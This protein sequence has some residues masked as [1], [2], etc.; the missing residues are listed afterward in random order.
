LIVEHPAARPEIRLV[1]QGRGKPVLQQLLK[2]LVGDDVRRAYDGTHGNGRG[3]R[4]RRHGHVDPGGYLHGRRRIADNR[5]VTSRRLLRS[6][7]GRESEG[8]GEGRA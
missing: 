7:V 5:L 4:R 8:E 3:R 1:V 6:R 2:L